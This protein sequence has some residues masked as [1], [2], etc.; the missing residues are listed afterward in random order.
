VVLEA[1]ALGRPVLSTFIAGTPELMVPGE[2]GWL[3]PAGSIDPL[4]AAPREVLDTPV[5][6]LTAV[7]R[8]GRARLV[9][10]HDVEATAR[11]LPERLV[12]RSCVRAADSTRSRF[13]VI[14]GE[15]RRAWSSAARGGD[16]VMSHVHGRFSGALGDE[17][18]ASVLAGRGIQGASL[19]LAFVGVL[20][21][22]AP[23]A[24]PSERLLWQYLTEDGYLMQAIARNMAIGRG[25]TTADGTIP[26]NGVQPLATFLFAAMH[27]LSG[28]DKTLGIALVTLVSALFSVG[29][30][31]ALRGLLGRA[32]RPLPQAVPLASL[33]AAL[34]FAAPHLV[35]ISMN[36]LETSCYHLALLLAAGYYLRFAEAP[37]AVVTWRQ[38]GVLGLLLGVAFLARNDAIFFIAALL[39]VHLFHGAEGRHG[40]PARRWVD[41]LVAGALS[42]V[43]ASPW[44]VYNHRLF[45][46][47]VPVSGTAQSHSAA[48]AD[49]LGF[50]PGK[51][52]ETLVPFLPLPVAVEERLWLAMPLL[53]VAVAFVLL[54][55]RVLPRECALMR[56]LLL[57]GVLFGAGLC[58]YYGLFFGAPWFLPRYFS[59]L[60][61][62]FWPAVLIGVLGLV[63][64]L[65]ARRASAAWASTGLAAAMLALA[66]GFAARVHAARGEHM[67]RQ[68]VE[69]ARA[70]VSEEVWV[71][72]VQTGTLGYFHD[73]TINLD[74]KVNP[75]ALRALLDVGHVQDYVVNSEIEYLID[76][77]GIAGWPTSGDSPAFSAA[78]EVLV[79]D[80][81]QNLGVVRRR[82]RP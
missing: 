64:A 52:F 71:G 56:R 17:R 7:G 20:V 55:L 14:F 36:G 60:S 70:H 27:W 5:E 22:L 61:L 54:S 25:M 11:S 47:I 58:V 4:V 35:P 34:W 15:C 42:V 18:L 46:S 72:A 49:N 68:V 37:E 39:L 1:L 9:A 10:Q 65:T 67:H 33:I 28:G 73:R 77:V 29:G 82:P 2:C 31:L 6:R 57:V 51:L 21:R 69:W 26:T 38:R 48:F 62:L 8:A 66:L 63:G 79:E 12:E 75:K 78:F 23:L 53:A 43:V 30:A 74:G 19:A 76:W 50:L 81:V 41:G 13:L 59:P 80:P 32:L 44:L 16:G 40:G 45:G 3:V 24:D